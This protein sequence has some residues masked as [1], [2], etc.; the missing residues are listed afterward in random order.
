M[1]KIQAKILLNI[2]IDVRCFIL[3][4]EECY[5]KILIWPTLKR[6]T[7]YGGITSYKFAVTL[8]FSRN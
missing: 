8:Q 1:E 7:S 3:E 2:C 4:K 5:F 6:N